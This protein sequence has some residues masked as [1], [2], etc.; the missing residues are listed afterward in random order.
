MFDLYLRIRLSSEKVRENLTST[1]QPKKL[2]KEFQQ[3]HMH[4]YILRMQTYICARYAFKWLTGK[5][6]ATC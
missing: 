2:L 5:Q 6:N 1:A 3:T 4:T